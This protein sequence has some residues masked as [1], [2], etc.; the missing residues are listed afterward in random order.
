MRA[1]K[2][3]DTFKEYMY[4]T[5]QVFILTDSDNFKRNFTY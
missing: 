5:I 2:F 3:F 1:F 4:K